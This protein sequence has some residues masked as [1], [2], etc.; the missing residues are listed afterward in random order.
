MSRFRQI[1]LVGVAAVGLLTLFL[2]GC[3]TAP[4]AWPPGKSPRVLA[5]FPP[6]YCFAANVA[7]D[8]AAVQSLLITV[9][10]HDY[11]PSPRDAVKLQGADLFLINGLGLDESFAN[12]LKNSA[13]SPRLRLVE[14][15]EGVKN[16]HTVGKDEHDH[17]GHNHGEHDPHVWLGIDQAVA[18][19]GTIRDE[20]ARVDLE[21]ADEYKEN[22]AKYVKA[23]RKLEAD[24]QKMLEAKKSKRIVSF[25]ESLGYFAH[26]FGLDVADVIEVVPGEPP[27]PGHLAELVELCRDKKK[28]VV[29]I[30][31]EPQY[32]KSTSAQTVK[33]ALRGKGLK[34]PLVEVDP[35]ETADDSLKKL[36]AR[37]YE[38]RMRQNLRELKDKLP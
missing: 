17:H 26:T 35:L 32:P 27:S 25:H 7:G 29:A 2:S 23:L 10:P 3:T 24:G 8:E 19:V 15:G 28:P 30:A 13:G 22:A 18:M 1:C 31:V 11:R 36:G 5:S 4:P 20:L 6:L 16:L 9:G 38:E 14:V 34:V 33:D 37:W 21:H 12:T